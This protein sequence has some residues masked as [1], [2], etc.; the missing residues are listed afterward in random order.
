MK[1]SRLLRTL[2]LM[3]LCAF[4]S[5]AGAN[6]AF[7]SR[8][9]K[10]LVGFAPGSAADT[11]ARIYA[12]KLSE[13]LGNNPVVVENRPGAAQLLAI[14][15]MQAAPPDGYTL[16]IATGSS[17]AQG[18]GLRTDLPYDPLKDFSLVGYLADVPGAIIVSPATGFKT[19]GDL[20]AYAKANPDK[21]NFGSSGVGSAGHLT[22]ELFMARTGIRMTHVPYKADT[23]AA[24]EVIAG[25]LQMAVTTLRTAITLTGDGKVTQLLTLDSKRLPQLSPAPSAGDAGLDSIKDIVPYTY[26]GLVGPA[27]LPADVV[28]R[29]NEAS[30]K[31]AA[32]PD[33]RTRMQ[34]AGILPQSGTP[35]ALRQFVE[36]EMAK[37]REVG[38]TVKL[39]PI[40]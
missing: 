16:Y 31:V 33:Y 1:L 9:I 37:W 30:A 13:V 17:L 32:M 18:P 36:K 12:Q 8:P 28:R 7:P 39:D 2:S 26:Y 19:I 25:T 4:S 11:F 10:I 27:R 22:G 5:I 21:L 34:E 35:L 3:A 14:K 6:D 20:I 15:G 24:R 38:K 40:R 23:E 29:L